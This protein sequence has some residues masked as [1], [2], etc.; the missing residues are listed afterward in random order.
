MTYAI[1]WVLQ[2]HEIGRVIIRHSFAEAVEA[3]RHMVLMI[4]SGIYF[5]N[6]DA[7]TDEQ[8]KLLDSLKDKITLSSIE[9]NEGYFH[10][11]GE[12]SVVIAGID[13]D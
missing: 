8:V 9:D 6:Y 11:S 13:G 4:E 7:P 10:P 1:C 5:D 3:A 12:W 2:S